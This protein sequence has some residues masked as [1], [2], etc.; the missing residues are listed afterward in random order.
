M[1]RPKP[2]LPPFVALFV[3]QLLDDG[4][5]PGTAAKYSAEVARF[6]KRRADPKVP[7]TGVELWDYVR[8][9][10]VENTAQLAAFSAAW[11]RFAAFAAAKG[12]PYPGIP[13]RETRER[14]WKDAAFAGLESALVV[15]AFRVPGAARVMAGLRWADLETSE[16]GH[17]TIPTAAD[18]IVVAPDATAALAEIRAS[19]GEGA[20]HVFATAEGR[21]LTSRELR[22]LFAWAGAPVEAELEQLALPDR[23]DALG[24]GPIT[25]E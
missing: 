18:P 20:A 14:A 10:A 12:H 9:V 2:Q 19:Q 4:C 16:S 6:F 11:R 13:D 8:R 17:T 15:V 3:G 22:A 7:V 23:G 25:S 1:P 21:V 5:A 24:A